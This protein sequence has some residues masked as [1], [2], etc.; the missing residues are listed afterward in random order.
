MDLFRSSALDFV[1]EKNNP[2]EALVS[3]GKVKL[4]RNELAEKRENC[5]N[6]KEGWIT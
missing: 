3:I 1:P 5:Q 2:I 4:A 6:T